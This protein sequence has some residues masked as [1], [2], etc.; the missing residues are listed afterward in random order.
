MNTVTDWV[1]PPVC[2]EA[3]GQAALS[4]MKNM[5]TL[6]GF[7]FKMF[8]GKT[9]RLAMERFVKRHEGRIKGIIS[10]FDRILFRTVKIEKDREDKK[11][12]AMF[13]DRQ[14]LHIY[15]YMVDREFGLMHVRLQTWLPLMIQVWINGW[16]F[17]ARRLDR[18]NMGYE[19]R[20]NCFA[21]R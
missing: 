10:G 6:H 12:K 5:A 16:E 4:M 13:R 21:H 1:S 3:A 18:Q 20:D 14:C 11:L 15:F 8:L 19:K 9:W 17:L 2:S 7:S